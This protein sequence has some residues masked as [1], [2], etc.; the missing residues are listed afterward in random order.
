MHS[1]Y[2]IFSSNLVRGD[3]IHTSSKMFPTHAVI[4]H[5]LCFVMATVKKCNIWSHIC[6]ISCYIKI[7]P[8][9]PHQSHPRL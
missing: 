4:F 6:R 5:I 1:Y 8:S 3:L 9:C 2:N 7:L